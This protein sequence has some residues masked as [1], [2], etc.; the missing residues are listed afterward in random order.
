MA[1]LDHQTVN[2]SVG[3]YVNDMAR[4]NGIESFRSML[5]R[6]SRAC[7]TRSVQ[8]TWTAM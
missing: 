6:S 3:E 2:H 4:T 5:K 8:S 1:D 7:S